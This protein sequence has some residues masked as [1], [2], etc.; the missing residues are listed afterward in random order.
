[1]PIK[2]PHFGLYSFTTGDTYSAQVDQDRFRI[3]D[4]SFSFLAEVI[5]DGII[6]GFNIIYSSGIEYLSNISESSGK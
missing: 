4:N 1:M 3:I 6:D 5:G 2:S